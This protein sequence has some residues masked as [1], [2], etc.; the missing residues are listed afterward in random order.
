MYEDC[1]KWGLPIVIVHLQLCIFASFENLHRIRQCNKHTLKFNGLI[2][3]PDSREIPLSGISSDISSPVK[4][5]FSPEVFEASF[6]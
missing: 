3:H 5:T 4:V 6:G 2:F 1:I